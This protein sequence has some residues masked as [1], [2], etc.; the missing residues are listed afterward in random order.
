MQHRRSFCLHLLTQ[1][2]TRANKVDMRFS[3]ISLLAFC[4]LLSVVTH[5]IP[6]K[7]LTAK[8]ALN[9]ASQVIPHY[10]KN[11]LIAIHGERSDISTLPTTW[12]V[13]FYV[14]GAMQNGTRVKIAGGVVQEAREGLTELKRGRVLAYA[15][16]E[17]ILPQKFNIDSLDA[18]ARLQ[19]LPP[20]RGAQITA[21]SFDLRKPATR[22]SPLWV[23]RLWGRYNAT[24]KPHFLGTGEVSA[25]TGEV[26]RF[27]RA[28]RWSR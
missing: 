28:P 7:T 16:E 22:F 3:A 14:P 26:I 5:E 9:L 21:T 25:E 18:L 12:Y 20:L 17:V 4:L 15:Q 24:S 23:I 6:A 11:N 19:A 10:A 27:R 13:W 8:Q 1:Q 2:F